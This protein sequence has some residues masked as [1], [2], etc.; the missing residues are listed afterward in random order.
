MRRQTRMLYA[1][2]WN[3]RIVAVTDEIEETLAATLEAP[4]GSADRPFDPESRGRRAV[5]G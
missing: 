3:Q 5:A 4:R 2:Y 1:V